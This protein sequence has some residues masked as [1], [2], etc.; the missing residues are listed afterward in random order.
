MCVCE[1]GR[2][3]RE[4]AIEKGHSEIASLLEEYE[5]AWRGEMGGVLRC[6]GDE[7][8]DGECG[9]R[10]LA[11]EVRCVVPDPGREGGVWCGEERGAEEADWVRLGSVGETGGRRGVG[12]VRLSPDLLPLPASGAGVGCGWATGCVW[13]EGREGEPRVSP[14][15]LLLGG[16]PLSWRSLRG[17][18]V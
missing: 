3:A 1:Q 15:D 11:R 17:A 8:G 18:G 16:D 9:E 5:R 7:R 10:S 14:T 6:L 12:K 2:T 4:Q 13:R